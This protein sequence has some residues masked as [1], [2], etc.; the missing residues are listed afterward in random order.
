MKNPIKVIVADDSSLM[1][2]EISRILE[3]DN[4]I[5][6]IATARNGLELLELVRKLPVDVVTLD[7]NMPKMNGLEALTVLMQEKPLP[8]L[9]VSSLTYEGADE[10]VEALTMGAFDFIHKPS[11]GISLDLREQGELIRNKVRL[12]DGSKANIKRTIVL[13][14]PEKKGRGA[15][16]DVSDVKTSK[17]MPRVLPHSFTPRPINHKLPPLVAIGVST[18][19]PKTLMSILPLIP[20]NFNGA[21]LIAQHMPDKF[22]LSFANRLDTVC[23]IRAKEVEDGDIIEPGVIYLAKG[24]KQTRISNRNNRLYTLNLSDESENHIY[25]P[26]VDILFGSLNDQV[27]KDWIGVLLTGMGA[28]GAEELSRLRK[29][30][31]HTIVESEKSCVVFGMPSRAINKGAAEFIL[32]QEEIAKKIIELVESSHGR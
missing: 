9:M 1:R 21:I 14:T 23:H 29:A 32:D 27:G 10:T 20:E 22:T 26:S 4:D 11:G 7:I 3:L 15:D 12:A 6:V 31:G 5:Q 24:G 19:G 2:M 13:P 17:G 30:G 16:T 18:G 28:D 8:V 25:K